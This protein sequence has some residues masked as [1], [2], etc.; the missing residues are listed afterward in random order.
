LF[1]FIFQ[2][3]EELAKEKLYMSLYFFLNDFGKNVKIQIMTQISDIRK[4]N[5]DS[6]FKN[7]INQTKPIVTIKD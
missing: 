1:I 2:T 4:I 7:L 3:A 5:Q 6:I